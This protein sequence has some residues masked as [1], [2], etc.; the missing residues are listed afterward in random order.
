MSKRCHIIYAHPA[1][2]DTYNFFYLY[3]YPGERQL[4]LKYHQEGQEPKEITLAPVAMLDLMENQASIT[5]FDP[6]NQV[7][8]WD[9]GAKS[10]RIRLRTWMQQAAQQQE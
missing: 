9:R 1:G 6:P 5:N 4:T 3:Y 2:K 10:L 7:R 8:A